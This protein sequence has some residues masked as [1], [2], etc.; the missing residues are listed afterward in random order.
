MKTIQ[1]NGLTVIEVLTAI[2][3]ALIGVAG[4]MVMI[5]FAVEQAKIG[6]DQETSYRMG[7]NLANEFEIKGFANTDRWTITGS[8]VRFR[9]ARNYVI[10]PI[11]VADRVATLPPGSGEGLFPFVSDTD[12]DGIPDVLEP[13]PLPP[14]FAADQSVFM[15]RVNLASNIAPNAPLDLELARHHMTWRDDL[16]VVEPS[17][18]SPG[19]VSPDLA[20]PRQVFDK[21]G[22]TD[23]RRQA[24]GEMSVMVVAVPADIV[25]T[26]QNNPPPGINYDYP[27]VDPDSD[28]RDL[29]REFR[30]YFVVSKSRP[31][32]VGSP[33]T[34]NQAFDRM[35]QVDH[36]VTA[37]NYPLAPNGGRLRMAHG[38]GTLIFREDV[39]GLQAANSRSTQRSE[40]RRGDW[41][42]LTNVSFNYN[43]NRY[44]QQFNFYQVDDATYIGPPNS[45]NPPPYYWQVT[46]RGP[47]F[48][49]G[50]QYDDATTPT[51]PQT[52]ANFSQFVAG[53]SSNLPATVP[54]RTYAIHL[55]DVWA[56]FEKTY[57]K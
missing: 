23:V 44:V 46:L 30:N 42:A 31:R 56:V 1:R 35:Y 9:T 37:A 13:L 5:P 4:V 27:T 6:F 24:L 26:T 36:P 16:Q 2:I 57:R 25:Q 11:G 18:P 39:G 7:A 40:I 17:I 47:D 54:S 14:N 38:G 3:V 43:S 22:S 12:S 15:E 55:P 50:W 49:F 52:Y 53:P 20:P 21:G 32:I 8:P 19:Y 48:D 51:N 10:D 28:A 45:T 29:V 34:Q 41:V 33:A